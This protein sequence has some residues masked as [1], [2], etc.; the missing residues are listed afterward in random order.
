MDI[1]L[2]EVDR[3]QRVVADLIAKSPAGVKLLLIGGFRYRLLDNSQRL[4]VDID[5]HWDG[6]L[7]EKQEQ[8]ERFCKRVVLREVKRLFRYEG[9][10]SRRKG[11]DAESEN[12]AFVDLRFWKEAGAIEIPIEI[13]TMVCLDP[14]TIR[15]VNG[16]IHATPSDAD[17]VEGKILAVLNR[18]YLQHRDFLDIFLYGDKLRPDAPDRM[19]QKIKALAIN[20]NSIRERLRDFDGHAQYHANAIQKVIDTQVNPPVA[21]QLNF[22]GGGPTVLAESLKLIKRVCLL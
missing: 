14:S 6:N 15:T 10:V 18:V 11:P 22:G 20:A 19:K 13:T 5:Y 7:H 9:S 3:I 8:I 16:T 2:Q 21:E 4:S 17:M 12:A 1:Q